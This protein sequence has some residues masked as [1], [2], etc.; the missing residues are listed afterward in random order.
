MGFPALFNLTMKG[1]LNMIKVNS[2]KENGKER[3][4][5]SPLLVPLGD[6]AKMLSMSERTVR[7][8]SQA[9]KLPPILKV[10]HLSRMKLQDLLSCI[11]RMG[12]ATV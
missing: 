4:L 10:G 1:K 3:N 7:R 8:N 12:G 2:Q 5:E 9:G 11:D 6:V